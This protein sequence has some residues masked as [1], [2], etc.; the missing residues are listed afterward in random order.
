MISKLSRSLQLNL[1]GA[2]LTL[3]G[4]TKDF[5]WRATFLIFNIWRNLP[6]R[7]LSHW[8]I[9]QSSGNLSLGWLRAISPC[10][11]INSIDGKARWLK[12]VI[13]MSLRLRS[14]HTILHMADRLESTLPAC[15]TSMYVLGTCS[16]GGP[17]LIKVP[18]FG[19]LLSCTQ[20]VCEASQP[21]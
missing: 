21:F 10:K 18:A 8:F 7:D 14:A 3:C 9:M 20:S 2:G 16:P 19:H 15:C 13:R 1:A 4:S 5:L 11:R 17:H 6:G 12:G